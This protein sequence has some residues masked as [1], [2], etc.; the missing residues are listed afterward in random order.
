VSLGT[1][2]RIRAQSP[3]SRTSRDESVQ[4]EIWITGLKQL[5]KPCS[6]I[7]LGDFPSWKQS[8]DE[9]ISLSGPATATR[10]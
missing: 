9:I 4:T 7:V 3:G 1:T 5:Q 2:R 6:E 10:N 8:A